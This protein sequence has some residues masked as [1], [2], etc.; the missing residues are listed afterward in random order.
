MIE[1]RQKV[2][3]KPKFNAKELKAWIGNQIKTNTN[4]LMLSVSTAGTGLGV[5][6]VVIN[7]QRRDADIKLREE[8]IKATN[9]LTDVLHKI[10]GLDT[11]E[12]KK[13]SKKLKAAFKKDIPEI[14]H[15]SVGMQVANKT[16]FRKKNEK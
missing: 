7:K 8:Q 11:K 1:F 16:I 14:E 15:P 2:F 9:E 13:H 10:Q 5:A 6:N 4:P 3:A 12:A